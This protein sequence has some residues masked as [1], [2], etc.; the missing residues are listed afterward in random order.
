MYISVLVLGTVAPE[1]HYSGCKENK[2]SDGSYVLSSASQYTPVGLTQ[3]P[4]LC[5]ELDTPRPIPPTDRHTKT[6]TLS[7]PPD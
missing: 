6:C 1:R 3:F 2:P 4:L 7:A 5:F